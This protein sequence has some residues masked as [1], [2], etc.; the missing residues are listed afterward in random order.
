MCVDGTRCELAA[1]GAPYEPPPPLEPKGFAERSD[2]AIGFHL[3]FGGSVRR[4]GID[5]DL[6]P[7]LGFNLRSD[8]PVL[9]Y[10]VLGPLIQFGAWR[11]SAASD[12]DYYLDVDLFVRGRLPIE[13]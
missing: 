11:P 8:F 9:R 12:R 3:G 5:A 2:S 13:L 6:D 10:L 1:S 7:T 4:A